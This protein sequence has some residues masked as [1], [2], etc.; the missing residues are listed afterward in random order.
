VSVAPVALGLAVVE[1]DPAGRIEMALEA[2]AM[3]CESLWL[4]ERAGE[5]VFAS[6][7]RLARR[8]THLRLGIWGHSLGVRHPMVSA[9]AIAEL[10]LESG[11]RAEVGVRDA[12]GAALVEAITVCKK[13]WCDPSVEYRGVCYELDETTLDIRPEQRPWPRLHLDGES[14]AS[15]GRAARMADGWLAFGHSIASIAAPLA[16]LRVLRARAETNDGR[17][18][19]SVR[20]E[21]ASRAE[22]IDWRNAGVDRLIVSLASLRSL[23]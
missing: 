19:I 18:Q 12:E 4:E 3:G 14:D 10:D 20:A 5:D 22:L 9:R 2:E 13:L 11:G 6:L 1:T 23:R 7:A 17:F 16:R 21:P 15:L 8:T